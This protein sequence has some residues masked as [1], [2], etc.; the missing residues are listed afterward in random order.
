MH[1]LIEK[2]SD[3]ANDQAVMISFYT[4]LITQRVPGIDTVVASDRIT[5]TMI[6]DVR[7]LP[8]NWPE[9]GAAVRE[10]DMTREFGV[11]NGDAANMAKFHGKAADSAHTTTRSTGWRDFLPRGVVR[12]Q[13]VRAPR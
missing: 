13:L 5:H 4:W 7:G 8:S 6:L 10:I 2:R 9:L 11:D 1:F 3:S 12:R